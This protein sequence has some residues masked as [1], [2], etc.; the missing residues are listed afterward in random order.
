MIRRRLRIGFP[1]R[2][3]KAALTRGD[4]IADRAA[5]RACSNSLFPPAMV[6]ADR[7]AV[8]ETGVP[9]REMLSPARDPMPPA[10]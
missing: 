8:P 4:L 3:I 10:A 9:S 5:A 1:Y 6:R 2:A 7:Q